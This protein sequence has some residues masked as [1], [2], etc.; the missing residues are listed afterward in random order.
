MFGEV[1]EQC[2]SSGVVVL[3]LVFHMLGYFLAVGVPQG[4]VPQVSGASTKVVRD[5]WGPS[6]VDCSVL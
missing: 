5:I 4:P 3:L 1:E 6:G 2:C